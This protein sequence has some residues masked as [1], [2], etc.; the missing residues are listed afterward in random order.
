MKSKRLNGQWRN[1]VCQSARSRSERR[2]LEWFGCQLAVQLTCQTVSMITRLHVPWD[3][4]WYIILS[5]LA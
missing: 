3:H 4:W 2:K 1:E 5:Q